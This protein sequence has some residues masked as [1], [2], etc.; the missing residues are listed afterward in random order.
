MR[1]GL[2]V[3]PL[4]GV[5][6]PLALAGSDGDAAR[7]ALAAG[8]VPV[9]GARAQRALH[10]LRAPLF[11]SA[12][13]MGG[14][15]A[16]A[17]GV[18]HQIVHTPAVVST[19]ADTIAAA[20]ALVAAG[21]ELIVFAGG[22][23]TARDLAGIGLNL[24]VLGIPAGVKM[25]S[26]LF[27]PSPASAAPIIA[28]LAAAAR[29]AT[30]P[31]EVL[32]RDEAGDIRLFGTLL[33]PVAAPRQ[34]A[35][36]SRFAADADLD[37]A[38][39]L[40]AERLRTAPLAIIGP[41]LTMHRLKLALAGTG[42]LLGVDVF[43]HGA[44]LVMNADAAQLLALAA[45]HAPVLALGVIGGQGF[46]LG[47]GN[48]QITPTLVAR[49]AWPPLVLASAAKLAALPGGRLLVDSGSEALDAGLNGRHI[50]AL[51]AP[52]R[53]MMMRIDAA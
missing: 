50:Q 45:D 16:A 19:A 29:C 53:T 28:A 15:V 44:P 18:P 9:A 8:A 27:A 39:A 23:G 24:P 42:T 30:E 14:D 48:Q 20:H 38:I 4:A 43:A 3:N 31:A 6:G 46:L 5:G 13:A 22:D 12:G 36:S 35:K 10:G 17:A 47:R 34:P 7:A 1:L 52:R 33:V 40:T 51:T 21:A 11:T 41:G 2:L 26:P 37:A 49:A 25:H 32:D